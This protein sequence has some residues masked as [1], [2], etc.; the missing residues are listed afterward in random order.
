MTNSEIIDTLGGTTKV[1]KMCMVSPPAASMW[2]RTGIPPDRMIFL[3][4]QLEKA[5][6]GQVTRKMLFPDT[7]QNIWIELT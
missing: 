7:W 2:R 5:T 3:A 6:N 4:A 1:A